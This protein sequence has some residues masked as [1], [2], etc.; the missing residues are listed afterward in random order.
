MGKIKLKAML[1]S[2][3]DSQKI[4]HLSK[5]YRTAPQKY[6]TGFKREIEA[7]EEDLVISIDKNTA[8]ETVKIA[9]PN[10]TLLVDKDSMQSGSDPS[11]V[12]KKGEK[13]TI[14]YPSA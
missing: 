6:K 8:D 11:L 12:L 4:A 5:R 2:K 3:I 1:E 10:K 14:E 13:A 9:G 7:T